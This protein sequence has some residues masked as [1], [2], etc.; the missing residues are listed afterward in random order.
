MDPLAL[1]NHLSNFM[2]PALWL[3]VLMTLAAR[4]FMKKRPQALSLYAQVA[5][6]FI[7][8]AAVLAL[9]LWLW[10]DDGKMATYSAMALFCASSQ[11]LMRRAWQP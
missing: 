6:N 9:G 2:A 10:G 8:S 3:A 11:W 4:F 1:L 7:V 5:I